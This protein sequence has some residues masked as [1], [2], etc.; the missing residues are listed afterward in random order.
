MRHTDNVESLA[1]T[2][3]GDLLASGGADG[4]ILLWEATSSQRL[5]E[6]LLGHRG[7]VETLSF[8]PTGS[9]LAS[10][11]EDGSVILWDVNVTSWQARA[12]RIANRPLTASELRQLPGGE[13]YRGVC[14]KLR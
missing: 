2:P 6:R 4:S 1:F 7:R 10:A 11:S 12:C 3:N 13:A 9:L 8:S 14:E 5:G